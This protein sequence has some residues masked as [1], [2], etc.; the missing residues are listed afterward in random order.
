MDEDLL[1]FPF[2]LAI[3]L[4][5]TSRILGQGYGIKCDAIENSG[6]TMVV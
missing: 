6:K 2:G 4:T 5:L 3:Y 1:D